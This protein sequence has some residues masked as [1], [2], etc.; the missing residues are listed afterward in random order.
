MDQGVIETV[1]KLFQKSIARRLLL[2]HEGR[3]EDFV[4]SLTLK[5]CCHTIADAWD[6]ITSSNL[7]NAWKAFFPLVS[8]NI[9]DRAAADNMANQQNEIVADTCSIFGQMQELGLWEDEILSWIS[10]DRNL[11]G[12]ESW[13]DEIMI[14]TLQ[15][16]VTIVSSP[17][18]D[19]EQT[20][21]SSRSHVACPI[22]SVICAN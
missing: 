2:K 5:D 10:E 21:Y 3:V 12:W 6:K 20:E 1:K 9:D 16:N 22:V 19:E 8:T 7:S 13:S 11:P 17:S 14:G 18:K 4:K 15:N